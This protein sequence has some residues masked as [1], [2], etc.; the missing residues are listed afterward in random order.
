MEIFKKKC[1]PYM[2][3]LQNNRSTI[4]SIYTQSFV[5]ETVDKSLDMSSS[6]EPAALCEDNVFC[7]TYK[8]LCILDQ[9]TGFR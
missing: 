6:Q 8:V 5:R 1:I 3:I 2:M 4:N 9:R 7:M